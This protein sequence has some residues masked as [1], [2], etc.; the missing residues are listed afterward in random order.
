MGESS[1]HARGFSLGTKL[2]LIALMIETITLV[3]GM[4]LAYVFLSET[5]M[6][7][8]TQLL[9]S[10]SDLIAREVELNKN[11][12]HLDLGQ[13][14]S[15]QVVDSDGLV[16]WDSRV[17][18]RAGA[19]IMGEHPLF[20]IAKKSASK[21]GKSDYHI[22]RNGEHF[23]GAY[24]HVGDYYILGSI[25]TDEIEFDVERTLEQFLYFSLL[26][27]GISFFAIVFFTRRISVPVRSLIAAAQKIAEGDFD[28]ELPRPSDDEIGLLS[29]TFTKMT[30]RI[31]ELLEGEE[32]KIR[33]EQEVGSVA[34]LQ[35][36]LLPPPLI[37]NARYEIASFY[38]SANET[39]GD[40]W[41]CF[42]THDHVVIYVGD[43]TGHGLPSAMMT[44]AARG[45]FSSL[46]RYFDLDQNSKPSLSFLLEHMNQAV[47][48][49]GQQQLQMTL[50][51]AL[52]S[53]K[54]KTIT[55][56]NAGHHAGIVIKHQENRIETLLSRGMRLG[57][58]T[59]FTAG[60]AKSIPFEKEDS[61]FIY[62]D[63]LTDLRNEA[64]QVLGKEPIKIILKESIE[65]LQNVKEIRDKIVQ[66]TRSYFP[67]QLPDD[68]ITFAILRA[69]V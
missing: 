28:I 60:E 57:E 34:E 22:S 65:K 37:R 10:Q 33:I 3:G 40:F 13:G 31:R 4:L 35:Q 30:K 58:S 55:Y 53:F 27:Y 18:K 63:G 64:G 7:Q 61:L 36:H 66:L 16:I 68:D 19:Q 41:G 51:V 9:L 69:K 26:M 39:G 50:F 20:S 59:E 8:F 49:V 48:D 44:A 12:S 62:S 25:S 52:V 21:S 54:E 29:E 47:L 1:L 38:Q 67:N 5:R 14:G 32:Q 17:P 6:S 24:R 46:K 23:L 2:I 43:A 11:F 42:E 45:C 56:A 15:Y